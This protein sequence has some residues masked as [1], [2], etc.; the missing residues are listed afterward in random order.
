VTINRYNA[1]RNC[2]YT[3]PRPVSDV[4]ATVVNRPVAAFPAFE[5]RTLA[6]WS[7]QRQVAVRKH[8]RLPPFDS[9][10]TLRRLSCVGGVTAAGVP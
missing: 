5:E 6:V 4:R 9:A 3:H 2:V 1:I 8:S 7:E 10:M